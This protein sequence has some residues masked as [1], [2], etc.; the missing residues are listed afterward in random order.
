M[1][2]DD[3]KHN[4]ESIISVHDEENLLNEKRVLDIKKS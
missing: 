4:S 1:L 2:Y 3:D